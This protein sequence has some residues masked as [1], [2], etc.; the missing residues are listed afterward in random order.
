MS[1]SYEVAI[2][3]DSILVRMPASLFSREEIVRFLDYLEVESIR[4]R[5][6]LTRADAEQLAKDIDQAGWRKAQGRF[7]GSE[8]L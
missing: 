4:R 5:S 3:E 7:G 6:Q 8:S 2:E 1:V